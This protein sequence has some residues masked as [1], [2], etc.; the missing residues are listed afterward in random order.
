M[1]DIPGFDSFSVVYDRRQQSKVRHKLI[2]IIFITVAAITANCNDFDTLIVFAEENETWLRKY[3]ELPNGLPSIDT[4]RRVLRAIDCGQFEKCFIR[5]AR[6]LASIRSRDIVA[7]DGKTARGA[8]DN[9]PVSAVHIVSAWMASE[10]IVMGQVKTSEKSNE[11]TA[12]PELLKLLSINDAIVTIDAMGTQKTIAKQIIKENHADYVFA[13]KGNHEVPLGDVS[14]YFPTVDADDYE[15][16]VVQSKTTTDNG[17]GRIE[18]R[19][20]TLSTDIGWAAWRNDWP[21][22]TSIGMVE[23]TVT[24]K[25]SGQRTIETRYFISSLDSVTPFARAIRDHWGIESL[26][27]SLDVTFREDSCRVRKD[28]GPFVLA[29]IRKIAISVLKKEKLLIEKPTSYNKIRYRA[30]MN[31]AY[32]T[33]VL[34]D[35]HLDN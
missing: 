3:L 8:R 7:I 17:H 13:L 18:R 10:G 29:I 30:S 35:N 9:Q 16:G 11:I 19:V 22:L 5:W 34:F 25:K 21:G 33:K 32:L 23:S 14:S 31:Q 2:D 6:E 24:N 15:R 4:Y 26:H 28:N 27:W 1:C 12:I 20:Y